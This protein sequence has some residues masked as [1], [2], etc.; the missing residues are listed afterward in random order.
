MKRPRYQIYRAD[1]LEWLAKRRAKSLHAVVTDPPYGI[2]EY[3]PEQLRMRATGTRGVWRLPQN[4]DGQERS[5]MPRFTVL[6]AAD[7][8][9][10][11]D[12]HARLAPLLRRVLVP[13]GHVIMACQNLLSH[14]VA[15]AFDEAGFEIRGQIVRVVKTLRGGDRPKGAHHEYPDVSVTPRSCWEPWLVLR[16]PCEGRVRDNLAK[17]RTGGLRRP[18]HG[19]PFRDL[20][21]SSPPR[22]EERRLV[23]HP[24]LKPQA[25][26]RQVVWA[27]LP[28]GKGVILDPFMGSGSTLA[29]A[30]HFGFRSIGLEICEEYYK[31]AQRCIP[32]LA[33]MSLDGSKP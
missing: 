7:R 25:F 20:I 17:W 26:M 11:R 3:L 22:G 33:R 31:L 10:V 5:P 14:V 1:A 23:S 30:E 27:A 13:G 12:F 29:A 16:R 8:Q 18:K 32:I 4:Y 24:S 28:L 9:R 6:N 21:E 15:S 2:I 19:G